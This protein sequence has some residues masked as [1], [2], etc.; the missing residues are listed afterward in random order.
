MNTYARDVGY[1]STKY[2][3]KMPIFRAHSKKMKKK[4]PPAMGVGTTFRRTAAIEEVVKMH[5]MAIR[6]LL[7]HV[8]DSTRLQELARAP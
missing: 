6:L 2:T 7:P 4:I 1:N 3:L 8:K 5:I